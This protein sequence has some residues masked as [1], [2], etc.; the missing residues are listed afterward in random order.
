MCA[1]T[2][3]VHL[4]GRAAVV[5][6]RGVHDHARGGQ[7]VDLPRSRIV[8]EGFPPVT[9]F[10]CKPSPNSRLDPTHYRILPQ[11]FHPAL[12]FWQRIAGS[13]AKKPGKRAPSSKP[14]VQPVP[15]PRLNI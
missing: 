9:P 4:E 1:L 15:S 7:A 14:N 11:P 8:P 3:A 10:I 5:A 6:P 12:P 2:V 13:R